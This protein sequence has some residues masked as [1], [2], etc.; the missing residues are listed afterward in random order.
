M[1]WRANINHK[2][3]KDRSGGW[4][5]RHGSN[6]IRGGY[7]LKIRF[8]TIKNKE[9]DMEKPLKFDG[10]YFCIDTDSDMCDPLA[11]RG[12]MGTLWPS[13]CDHEKIYAE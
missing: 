10:E 3:S 4:S 5:Y 1:G 9:M 12:C 7:N 2:R 8:K 11:L 6:G 13:D